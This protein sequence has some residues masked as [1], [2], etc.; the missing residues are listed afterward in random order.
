MWWL[1]LLACMQADAPIEPNNTE[2]VILEVPSGTTGH[3]LRGLLEQNDLFPSDVPL[4]D[5]QWKLFLRETDTRC[6]KAGRF[7]V[8]RGLSLNEL[9]ATL[10]GVP[11]SDD[12]PFTVVEGWRIRDIDAALVEKGWIEAGAFK[13]LA[14]NPPD[15]LSLPHQ[16]TSLEGYLFPETYQVNADPFDPMDLLT[17]QVET[18][19]ERFYAVYGDEL[20]DRSLHEVVIMASL[21]EREEPLDKNRPMVAGILYK[22]IENDWALGVDATSRY[23]LK[24][25]NNRRAF[26]KQLRDPSDPYNTRLNKGLPPTPI[27]SPSLSALKAAM[28]P[29]DSPYWYYL[30]DH[31]GN[32]HPSR[33]AA[34]HEALRAKHNVY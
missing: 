21:L 5:L 20:G 3:R 9:V 30:H 18:F 13:A 8:H 2:T 23:T 22:R 27:G 28:N 19:N 14:N 26:L 11:L 7:E 31:Q 33:N 1:T 25:W 24:D 32:L 4:A 10:C 17:R 15:T 34:E 16:P 6:L 12:V 29:T